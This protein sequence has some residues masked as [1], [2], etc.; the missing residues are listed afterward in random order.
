MRAATFSA[1]ALGLLLSVAA[2]TPDRTMLVVR[3]QSNI[4]VPSD[5]NSVRVV[6]NHAGHLI[7]D[8]PFSLEAGAQGTHTLPLQVGLLSPSGG[9]ADVEITVN[10]LLGSTLVVSQ[11][12]VTSFVKGKSLVLDMFL[13]AECENFDCQDPNK[14][15]T[16]GQVCVAKNRA[17]DTLPVFDPHP[18][19]P[20]TDSGAGDGEGGAGGT[21]AGDASDVDTPADGAGGGAGGGDASDDTSG[22]AGAGDAR[23]DGAGG[24]AVE[25]GP[26]VPACV[27]KTEDCFNGLD[28]D[29]DGLPD[30]ADP[31]CAPTAVCVPRPSGDVG[32]NVPG[33]QACP[34]GFATP[35][36]FGSGLQ[37]GGASCTGCQCGQSVVTSCSATLT[38]YFTAAECQA[39]TNG[40]VVATISTTDA[41]TCPVPDTNTA[42]VLGAGLSPWN[43][44]ST[45]CVASGAPVRPTPS[46][47]TSTSFCKAARVSDVGKTGC[48]AGSVCMPKPATGG[49]CVLLADAGACPAGTKA[50]MVVYAGIQDNR[51]CAACSCTLQGANCDNLVVQMGSDYSCG[52]DM[53]D[54]K[55]GARN[56]MPTQTT[57]VYVPGYHLTGTPTNGTC[58]PASGLSGPLTPTGGRALCC[59]P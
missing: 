58:N 27:P 15:C 24:G 49:S 48:A 12:A 2:C 50:S 26:E 53:E 35:T 59:L 37:A 25:V 47:A 32:T 11:D 3:V 4:G 42:N 55:G 23:P 31:D 7:Q 51:T 9:G 6:V 5:M 36:P 8:L 44:V 28:D 34:T 29:C 46:F 1:C 38:T 41:N 43:V 57:G 54:I 33:A 19:H 17:A 39:G 20:S 21:G 52:V 10:G 13:A 56:C 30:C 45:T 16:K 18:P 40:K 22:Q 14:T